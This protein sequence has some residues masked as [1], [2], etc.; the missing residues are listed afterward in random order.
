M[1]M[2]TGLVVSVVGHVALAVAG[3]DSLPIN[4]LEAPDEGQ[5]IELIDI[6]EIT[7]LAIGLDTAVPVPEPIPDPP[8][9]DVAPQP[10]PPP[11][12]PPP[13]DPEPLL[14][15]PVVPADDPPAAEFVAEPAVDAAPEPTPP[16]EPDPLPEPVPAAIVPNPTPRPKAEA[17]PEPEPEP[18]EPEPE[19]DPPVIDEA[20]PVQP[21]EEDRIAALLND[22][23][24]DLPDPALAGPGAPDGDATV[25]EMTRSEVDALAAAIADCWYP[26]NGWVDPAEVRV[27]VQFRLNRDGT[28]QGVPNVVQAPTGRYALVATERALIA[29]RQCAPYQLPPDKYDAWQEVRITFDPIE[30]FLP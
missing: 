4:S 30:M 12:V 29:V 10:E 24:V 5:P 21:A 14:E 23:A 26:P 11:E 25:T 7:Q 2:R 27:V 16:A 3:L 28:V 18:A 20:P 15:E 13:A 8:A 19:P 22:P 1:E 17:E 6:A 9:A